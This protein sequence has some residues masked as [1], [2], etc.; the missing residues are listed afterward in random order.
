MP[1]KGFI[2]RVCLAAGVVISVTVA[3]A[4]ASSGGPDTPVE[5]PNVSVQAMEGAALDSPGDGE[6]VFRAAGLEPGDT[7]SGSV[8][9]TNDGS[10]RGMFWLAGAGFADRQGPNGGTLS[11][12]LQVTVLDVSAP[13]EPMLVYTGGPADLNA[14]PLGFIAPGKSRI[15]NVAATLLPDREARP[16][17]TESPYEG[18]ST[19]VNLAWRAIAG[20][21]PSPDTS[22][23][24]IRPRDVRAP[25]LTL[26]IPR[27][28]R[29]LET[30]GLVVRARCSEDCRLG[31]TGRMRAEGQDLPPA[32]TG[33][34][35]ARGRMKDLRVTFGPA[36]RRAL[37]ESLLNGRAV[38]VQLDVSARDRAGNSASAKRKLWLR[39]GP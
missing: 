1:P 4:L 32:A 24:P 7:T 10:S 39:P 29:L 5:G 11:E 27:T 31:A 33:L 25:R 22:R 17:E 26:D 12:R 13:D 21:P 19:T 36:A 3:M 38:R 34:R 23:E 6:A 20:D 14:R 8:L 28:Q 9:V 30:G 15:Y 18:S 2:A 35:A 37:S 16:P